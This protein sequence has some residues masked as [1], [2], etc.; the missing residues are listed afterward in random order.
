[1]A[2]LITPK[3][4]FKTKS[5]GL[6]EFYEKRNKILIVR[7]CGGVGD[8]LMIR[9]LFEDF[10]KHNPETEIHF[11]CPE[12]FHNL[13]KDHHFID[14]LLDSEQIKIQEYLVSYNISSACSRYEM[15]PNNPGKHR[16]DIW[17]NHCGLELKNHNMHINLD[18]E[19]IQLGK[20]VVS[21]L[22]KDKSQPFVLLAPV[23]ASKAK[24]LNGQQ[25]KGL[26]DCLKARN[27]FICGIHSGQIR[28]LEELGIPVI[29]GIGMK[30]WMGIV[31]AADYVI[32]VDT[33]CFHLAG[34]LGRPL[35]GI[36]TYCDGKIYSKYYQAELVQKHIDKFCPCY[37]MSICPLSDAPI[38]PCATEITS[39]MLVDGVDRMFRRW[40]WGEKNNVKLTIIN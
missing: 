16:S 38:K 32:S 11:A 2:R 10:K 27:C 5:F 13:V 22:K 1:M 9:F 26:V 34:G 36:F 37:N 20:L 17:A 28:E 24:D 23:S 4:N 33:G 3:T 29:Y 30:K 15:N 7:E 19:S 8:I 6:K 14:K 39:G 40:P 35:M 12:R 31:N 25:L 21:E 18:E